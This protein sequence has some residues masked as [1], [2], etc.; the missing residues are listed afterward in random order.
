MGELGALGDVIFTGMQNGSEHENWWWGILIYTLELKLWHFP[1]VC[2]GHLRVS[3]Q[4][5][6]WG[7]ESHAHLN[8]TTFTRFC[9]NGAQNGSKLEIW[10]WGIMMHAH[11]SKVTAFEV[12]PYVYIWET[13]HLQYFP[14][15]WYVRG[16]A[17][18]THKRDDHYPFWSNLW[19]VSIQWTTGLTFDPK[20]AYKMLQLAPSV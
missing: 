6:T 18:C 11:R 16:G 4:R 19:A 15:R 12:I 1:Y 2:I 8:V 13:M 14:P 10:P 3:R 9:Q 20:I 5:A 17:T 7:A